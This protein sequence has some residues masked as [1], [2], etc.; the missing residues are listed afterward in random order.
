MLALLKVGVSR[1]LLAGLRAHGCLQC[2][3]WLLGVVPYLPAANVVVYVGFVLAER[4]L[5]MPS[6]GAA[7]LL[8]LALERILAAAPGG[9][10][11]PVF[12]G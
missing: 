11:W 12:V 3:A 7:L 6:T 8:A 10:A 4:V 9:G 1:A 5:Y 2:L